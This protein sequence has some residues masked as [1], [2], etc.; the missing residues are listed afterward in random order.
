MPVADA[1]G[2]SDVTSTEDSMGANRVSLSFSGSA[3]VASNFDK[4]ARLYQR[5]SK[6]KKE[7]HTR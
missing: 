1:A 7:R 2:G 3:G 5:D 4:L 6:K